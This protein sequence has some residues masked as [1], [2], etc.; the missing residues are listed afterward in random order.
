LLYYLHPCRHRNDNNSHIFC[1]SL[2][3][4]QSI[5]KPAISMKIRI[6]TSLDE[7]NATDWD[8]LNPT[9]NPTL[10]HRFLSALEHNNCVG[11]KFGWIGHHLAAYDESDVLVGA[12]LLYIKDNSYGELVF[13]WSW[14]DAFHRAGLPYY[15]KGV[16]AI[17]YTPA[18]GPRLLI[19]PHC[20]AAEIRAYLID[21]ALQQA[22]QLQLSSLHW[23]FTDQADTRFLQQRGLIVR[24]DCQYHW[25]NQAYQTFDDFLSRLTSRRRK[26]IRRERRLACASGLQID[27][28]NGHQ[29][30]AR[31]LLDAAHFYQTTYDKK[32]GLATLNHGFFGELAEHAPDS[33]LLI[34]A[35]DKQRTIACAIFFVGPDT[36]YGRNWGC[37]RYVANLHFELCYY[38]GIEY[39]IQ[40]GLQHFEP[41]AQGE[42]KISRGFM[43]TATWSAHWIAHDIFRAAITD[44]A[45]NEKRAMQAHIENLQ[46]KSPYRQ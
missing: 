43:P 35:R 7:I 1:D 39:C 33:L 23:L 21:A 34:F 14:A 38:Q 16:C 9:A 20:N 31:Q 26:E 44:Y 3:Y 28:V 32:A 2:N 41:G 42:H 13:D 29:A 15:P 17:P 24:L 4:E 37:D 40:N 12:M 19:A 30:S 22:E 8:R 25:H 6:H 5:H 18:T 45:R 27:V 36:L 10:S 11:Q 46:E